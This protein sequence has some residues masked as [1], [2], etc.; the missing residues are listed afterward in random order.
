MQRG[1]LKLSGNQVS[2]NLLFVITWP[3]LGTRNDKEVK[4]VGRMFSRAVCK[5]MVGCSGLR[6]AE[7]EVAIIQATFQAMQGVVQLA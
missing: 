5:E 1:F 4:S 3:G 6:N 2:F 7:T